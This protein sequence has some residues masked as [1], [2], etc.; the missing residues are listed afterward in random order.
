MEG[1]SRGACL[2]SCLAVAL[3]LGCR[4]ALPPEEATLAPDAD[5]FAGLETRD[6]ISHRIGLPPAGCVS[7]LPDGEACEWRVDARHA[8]YPELRRQLPV[9]DRIGVICA[10]PA[11]GGTLAP[12]ACSLHQRRSNRSRVS[13]PAQ[14]KPGQSRS[15]LLASLRSREQARIDAAQ[16]LL[17][18]SRTLGQLPEGCRARDGENDCEWRLSNTSY[19]HGTVALLV[20]AGMHQKVRWSCRFPNDGSPRGSESCTGQGL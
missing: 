10:L 13:P 18:M 6:E 17:E 7:L 14:T 4:A 15:K 16:T 5:L 1:R 12:G 8:F 19:G 11:D 9:R 20:R 3:L 2:V